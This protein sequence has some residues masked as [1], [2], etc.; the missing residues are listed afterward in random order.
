MENK[1]DKYYWENEL[2]DVEAVKLTDLYL[3]IQF[4]SKVTDDARFK[5][6]YLSSICLYYHLFNAD[7]KNWIINTI[8]PNFS[9]EALITYYIINLTEASMLHDINKID[10]IIKSFNSIGLIKDI[11]FENDKFFL[12]TKDDK[13]I[14]F[15]NLLSNQEE[16]DK[17]K[18]NCHEICESLL[19]ND[20]RY[21]DGTNAVTI[22]DRYTKGYKLYH[23]I[24]VKENYAI[25]PARNILMNFD[26]YKELFNPEIINILSREEL[27]KE[28]QELSELDKEFSEGENCDLL[29]CAMHKQ[30][31]KEKNMAK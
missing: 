2:K 29:K 25:D 30:M 16:A 15:K 1:Y 24:L 9:K 8:L 13:K 26:N 21:K 19:L 5:K 27:I 23:S 10:S 11:K 4:N 28:T 12:I 20:E 6:N 22:I 3:Q 18:N 14:K 7:L 17:F 31:K